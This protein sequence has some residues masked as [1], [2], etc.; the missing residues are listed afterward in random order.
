MEE[1][2]VTIPNP[3]IRRYGIATKPISFMR[4]LLAEEEILDYEAS[5]EDK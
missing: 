2:L 5:E 3:P 4:T 1:L